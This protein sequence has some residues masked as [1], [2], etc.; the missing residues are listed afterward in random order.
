MRRRRLQRPCCLR[1]R[2][3]KYLQYML[4]L[5]L[6]FLSS[7]IGFSI[8]FYRNS[9]YLSQFLSFFIFPESIRGKL[10]SFPNDVFENYQPRDFS[11]KRRSIDYDYRIKYNDFNYRDPKTLTYSSRTFS[12]NS[13]ILFRFPEKTSISALLLIFHSC[14]HTAY[15]WF[16]TVERQRIIGG[17]IELGYACLVFQAV[18]KI[19]QCWSNNADI[20]ENKDVQMVFEGLDSF[21]KQYPELGKLNLLVLNIYC[22]FYK[23]LYHVLHLVHQVVEYFQVYLL[24]II[25]IQFK[26]KFYLF[27]LFFQKYCILMLK[28]KIIHQLFGYM[29]VKN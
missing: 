17:A 8:T 12:N 25:V 7:F 22:F 4:V 15:D 2:R 24:L 1:L 10:G 20:Y 26:D 16:H 13:E 14:K 5:S 28:Q 9:D 29:Y 3:S 23:Y 11:G 18:D 19:S 27:Q 6:S 21:Y